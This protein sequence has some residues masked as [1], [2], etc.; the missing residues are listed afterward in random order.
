MGSAAG[1]H[2][3][4]DI[5]LVVRQALALGQQLQVVLYQAV[6]LAQGAPPVG[7]HGDAAAHRGAAKAAT[8][9]VAG[10]ARAAAVAAAAPGVSSQA[11]WRGF[12]VVRGSCH[13]PF[14]AADS[15]FLAGRG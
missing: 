11:S 3:Q 9:R 4:R 13:Y 6:Q 7:G 14:I 5:R 8:Q 15:Y 10:A 1:P 12:R 2:L